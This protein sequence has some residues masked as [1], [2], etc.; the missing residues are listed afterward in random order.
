MENGEQR[1]E[2]G[3]WRTENGEIIKKLK[4]KF[5]GQVAGRTNT[6]GTME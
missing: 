4:Y 2:N 5:T 1:M 3:E 6:L